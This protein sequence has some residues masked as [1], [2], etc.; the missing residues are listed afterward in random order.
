MAGT[1]MRCALWGANDMWVENCR[2]LVS[3]VVEQQDIED[4]VAPNV[5]SFLKTQESKVRRVAGSA[6]RAVVASM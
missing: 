6:L 3:A 4:A 2:G 1:N 5:D